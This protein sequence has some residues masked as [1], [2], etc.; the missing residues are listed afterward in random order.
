MKQNHV[1]VLAIDQGTSGTAA[2]IYNQKG[3]VVA[4]V[5][6]PV[7]SVFPQPGWVEQNP[8]ELLDSIKTAFHKLIQETNLRPGQIEC[9]G[10][11][12]QGETLVVWDIKTGEPIYNVIGWQCVRS[13]R[14]CN[15][16]KEQG[17]EANFRART[18]LPL[19]PEWPATKIPW[20]RENVHNFDKL[21]QEQRL[22][23][24]SLDT[25]FIHQ[26][27][28][29]KPLVTDH[30]TV[31]RSGLYNIHA[32]DWDSELIK[33]FKAEKLLLPRI[34]DSSSHFG[35]IDFGN[36][37]EFSWTGNALDQSAAMLGQ[38]CTQ[39]GDA[40][41]TY[42]TCVGFW[43]NLG[44]TAIDTNEMEV[45]IAWVI[46]GK[47]TYALV[48]ETT[49]GGNIF[50]WLREKLYIPWSNAELSDIAFS[51]QG[52]ENLI[53]VP[54]LNG[55]GSPYWMP[56]VR[57]S[58]FGLSAGVGLE[59]LVRAGLEAVAFSVCDLLRGFTQDKRFSL[60]EDIFVDGGMTANRY[61]MQFQANLLGKK[62]FIPENIEG[63]STGVAYLAGIKSG[64]YHDLDS[65]R[66]AWKLRQV[67]EPETSPEERNQRYR[68]WKSTINHVIDQY[69]EK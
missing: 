68:Q 20:M 43:Y 69:L 34:L 45:S 38:S 16:L 46:D 26:L 8:Y 31:S 10:L 57:G 40:K 54:A 2:S 52:H 33:I 47:P 14:F 48:G 5:D 9:M 1:F 64:Y 65:T 62:I 22:V 42:G 63:T 13:E 59:H 56:E 66:K 35:T 19:H 50:I 32:R 15:E 21:L 49:S 55:L 23:F 12:N 41:I 53:F 17:Y 6:V 37:W 60:P 58:I 61:L 51:A 28:K 3:Q 24:S 30:S 27:T 67:Y 25:W 18:G 44:H 36:G 11:A 29:E 39:P 4:S 7:S